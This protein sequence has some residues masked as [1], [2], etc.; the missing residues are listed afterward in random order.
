MK[1]LFQNGCTA[2]FLA[3]LLCA[4]CNSSVAQT[5]NLLCGTPPS[6][7]T[8]RQA[9]KALINAPT[10]R[11]TFASTTIPIHFWIFRKNNDDA[12]THLAAIDET[13]AGANQRFHFPNNEQFIRCKTDYILD[14]TY[15]EM[16]IF[17][18]SVLTGLFNTYFDNNAINIYIVA[19]AEGV[20]GVV[21]SPLFK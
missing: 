21:K 13:L 20:G 2:T 5:S 8:E 12:S 17:T 19:P 7:V 16:S 9:L 11:S 3:L 15:A 18:P 1:T 14:V 6:T 10:P 4:Y